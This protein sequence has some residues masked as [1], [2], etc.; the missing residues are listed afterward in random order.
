MVASLSIAGCTSS[1]TKSNQAASSASQAASSAVSTTA[2]TMTSALASASA[3]PS[4]MPTAGPTATPAP[5][6][7]GK[8][9]VAVRGQQF[10]IALHSNPTTGYEW[11][12]TFDVGAVEL[13]NH[14]FISDFP[15][16]QQ[17]S[18]IGAGGTDV[19]TFEALRGGAT[20]IKF[21][22]VRSFESGSL[23]GTTYIVIV[24]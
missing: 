2:N 14:T 12:P 24:R 13:K 19:F 7:P 5:T 17:A 8:Q 9:I 20:S 1:S 10:S 18:H 16:T 3:T 22:Y 23:N 21:D 11:Q 4:A 15:V 6:Q